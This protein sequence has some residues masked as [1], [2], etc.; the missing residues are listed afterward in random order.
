M[1]CL[2]K[3][4]SNSPI[5]CEWHEGDIRYEKHYVREARDQIKG[6]CSLV[7]IMHGRA[8]AQDSFHHFAEVGDVP[9]YTMVV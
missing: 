7:L 8:T 4:K 1:V 9:G 5:K 6:H 2:R 3:K